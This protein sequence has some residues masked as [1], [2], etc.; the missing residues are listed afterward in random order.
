MRGGRSHV[1]LYRSDTKTGRDMHEALL[2]G[3]ARLGKR[4]REQP[5]EPAQ[6]VPADDAS[7]VVVTKWTLGHDLLRTCWQAGIPTLLLDKG[8][9]SR[10]GRRVPC[11]R[12]CPNA[13]QPLHLL[14]RLDRPADRWDRLGLP[15]RPLR[16]RRGDK[17]L[18]AGSSRKFYESCGLPARDDCLLA[19]AAAIRQHTDR[20]VVYRPKP[21]D[22]DAGPLPGVPFS[23]G[24]PL[25][26]DLED[27]WCLVTHGSSTGLIAWVH[28][29]PAITL[30][31]GVTRLL[32]GTSVADVVSPPA[33]DIGTLR[34]FCYDLAY[35]QYTLDE[36]STGR[37]LR[38][39]LGLL[40]RPVDVPAARLL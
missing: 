37:P 21:A 20:P 29:V 30:G 17:I 6:T 3:F 23:R 14:G 22:N 32:G 1:V 39:L 2:A 27:A 24:G 12:I 5:I 10:S 33:T 13:F 19:T 8:Y 4:V 9:T 31:P 26:E 11:V 35:L 18:L 34:S 40:D 7:L 38:Y 15:I 36:L 16:R 25:S 28:G